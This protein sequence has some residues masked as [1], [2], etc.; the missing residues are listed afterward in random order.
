MRML[1]LSHG[2][3]P[4]ISGVTLVVQKISR[5]MVSRGHEVTV[6][7]ASETKRGY[8]DDDQGVRLIRLHAFPNPFWKEG[9][10]PYVRLGELEAIVDEFQ[11]DL[12]HTHENVILS[13]QLLRLKKTQT[14]PR[15][16]SC[17]F[18][19]RYVTHYLRWPG[20]K[21]LLEKLIWRIAIRNLNQYDHTIFSTS[22][23]EHDYLEHGLRVPSTVI[24]NGVDAVRYHSTNGREQEIENRYALPAGPR[25]L[26]V[27]R[28]AKDKKIDLLIQAMANLD[29][30]QSAH[31][32][33]VGRGDDRARLEEVVEELEVGDRVHFLGFVPE[34]DLPE[35]YRASDI[36]TIASICEVQS[37]PTLQAAVSGLPIVAVNAAALPELVEDQGNGRL[38]PPD[39]PQAISEAVQYILANP[40]QKKSFGE[41]SLEIGKPHAQEFTFQQY[42]AF[43]RQIVNNFPKG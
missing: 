31:L 6:V 7:T 24:S 43:Y 25:L 11:P 42:D 33:I 13:R 8:Q 9:P 30:Q 15:V 20:L 36:F 16:S 29:H 35:I 18:L 3:P 14:V 4:T 2:Y 28:L 41:A 10:I 40:Q 21:G 23:Q 22:S 39:D 19:P 5:A 32:L 26:F 37:I 1:M 27:G 17:Y 34:E 38:V 12:I